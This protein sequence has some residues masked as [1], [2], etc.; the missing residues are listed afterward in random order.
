MKN[1]LSGNYKKVFSIGLA[2]AFIL[3]GFFVFNTGIVFTE[4]TRWKASA[5]TPTPEPQVLGETTYADGSLLR[6]N[7][8]I[9]VYIVKY[10]GDKKF[11]R[12]I[13]S[14][15]VFASYEHLKWE[16]V[17]D[18]EKA[19][20]DSFITSDLV[21]ATG[22]VKVYKLYPNGDIGEKRWIITEEAFIRLGYDWDSIYEINEAEKNLYTDGPNIE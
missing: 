9:D 22:D 15:A 10:V 16:D 4:D 12:L 14:P 21:R 17:I 13:L 6:E 5:S 2:A 19:V 20:L 8:G 3:C 11:K 1:I 7:G 18:V